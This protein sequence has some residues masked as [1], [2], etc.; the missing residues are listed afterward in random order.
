MIRRGQ[1]HPTWLRGRTD[2]S[3]NVRVE[4]RDGVLTSSDTASMTVE[5]VA[6]AIESM[7]LSATSILESQSITVTGKFTDP[8]RGVAKNSFLASQCGVTPL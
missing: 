7:D 5:N 4:V 8:A 2:W 1:T 3:G 6:P